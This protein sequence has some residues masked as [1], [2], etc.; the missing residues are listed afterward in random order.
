MVV[1]LI[2]ET[3]TGF[4]LLNQPVFLPNLTFDNNSSTKQM[5]NCEIKCP[6]FYHSIYDR[7]QEFQ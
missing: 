1:L 4:Y 2:K 7:K 6:N 5:N 3:E